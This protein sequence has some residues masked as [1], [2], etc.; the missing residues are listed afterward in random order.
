MFISTMRTQGDGMDANEEGGYGKSKHNS[1][2]WRS[3]LF[4]G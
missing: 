3:L 1:N 4:L 2:S